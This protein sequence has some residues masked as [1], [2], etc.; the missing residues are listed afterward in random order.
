[1]K[2]FLVKSLIFLTTLF[3][4]SCENEKLF[5]NNEQLNSKQLDNVFSAYDK[6]NAESSN[7]NIKKEIVGGKKQNESRLSKDE[8]EKY[9]ISIESDI[10]KNKNNSLKRNK[11]N[12]SLYNGNDVG[13]VANAGSCPSWS[14]E[15][16]IFMDNEDNNNQTS[17]TY[18]GGLPYYNPWQTDYNGNTTL[19]YCRVDGGNFWFGVPQTIQSPFDYGLLQLGY[20]S[21]PLVY[22]YHVNIDNEDN[23]N[24]TQLLSG[25]LTIGYV[26]SNV[27]LRYYKMLGGGTNNI[28]GFPNFGFSYGVHGGTSNYYI[29]D[30]EDNNN[31]SITSNINIAQN[32]VRTIN[33]GG[34]RYN[35]LFNFAKIY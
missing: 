24:N 23:S 35:T 29:T 10:Q 26:N 11:V 21:F 32:C 34:N 27:Q 14:E 13:V 8:I 17:F 16:S 7:V 25:N 3:Y 28:S 31:A 19:T 4:F 22:K 2:N 30:D 5:Y 18:N 20:S 1:M 12:A 33:A 6:L 9:I 15:I